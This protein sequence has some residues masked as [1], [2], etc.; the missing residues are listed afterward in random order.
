MFKETLAKTLLVITKGVAQLTFT[1]F[2][3]VQ[4]S[5]AL[6][7]ILITELGILN[8]VKPEHPEKALLLILITELGI[9]NVVRPEHPEKAYASILITELGILNAVKPEQ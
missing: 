2:K 4:Y 8:V 3:P 7:P 5:K 1:D 9:L 6:E